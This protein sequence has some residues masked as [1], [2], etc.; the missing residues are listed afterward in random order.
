M[1]IRIIKILKISISLLLILTL[2]GLLT[3]PINIYGQITL[4]SL[5]I[6]GIILLTQSNENILRR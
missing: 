4:I 5:L 2:L 6:V 3:Y 1:C